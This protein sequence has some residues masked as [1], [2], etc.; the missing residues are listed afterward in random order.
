M[1]KKNE[2]LVFYIID[3]E[4]DKRH[5]WALTNEEGLVLLV[6][7]RK[8]ELVDYAFD[9]LNATAVRHNERFP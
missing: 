8:S 5:P 9:E 3:N 2:D 1:T 4:G 6:S 7:H